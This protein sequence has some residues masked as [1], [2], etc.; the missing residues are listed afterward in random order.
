KT[1]PF[2]PRFPYTI[3]TKNCWQ[4]Y[5]DFQKCS[6]KLGEDNENCQWFKRTFTSLCPRAW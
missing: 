6:K 5:V 1:A 3:Q 4:N 2:D